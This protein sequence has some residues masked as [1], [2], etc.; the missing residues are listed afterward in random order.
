MF[1]RSRTV[2]IVAA[3]VLA[4]GCGS[5]HGSSL[6]RVSS[7]KIP[8]SV[9]AAPFT[10][11]AALQAKLLTATDM[12]PGFEQIDNGSGGGGN[13]PT[14]PDR[15]HTSPAACAKVLDPVSDQVPG[16][17]AGG[18][19]HYSSADFDSIDIDAASY[20]N[21]AAAQAFST[22]QQLLGDCGS[23]SGTDADG[24][25][26]SYQVGG[27]NQ[28]RAGDASVS[29]QVRTTSQGMTLYSAATVALVGSTVVQVARAAQKPVDP[30]ALR[31][32]T[33]TQ[34]QRLQGISGP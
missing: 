10:D 2:L 25:A 5:H 17:T 13:G 12:P 27:L 16:S 8:S 9:T 19:V 3:A 20:P 23:Y 31:G 11:S 33:D 30:E 6:P 18:A 7:A 26:V 34:V 14:Q 21:K 24:T 4:A 1:S 28:A 32:L 29:F 22:V 15:S